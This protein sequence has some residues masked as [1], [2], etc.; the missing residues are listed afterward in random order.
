M[1]I[2]K[3][4][5]WRDILCSRIVYLHSNLHQRD[6]KATSLGV[7]VCKK[8]LQHKIFREGFLKTAQDRDLR[9]KICNIL[10]LEIVQTSFT[11]FQ[12]SHY[13]SIKKLFVKITRQKKTLFSMSFF[14]SYLQQQLKTTFWRSLVHFE[15][16]IS[17]RNNHHRE[18]ESRTAELLFNAFLLMDL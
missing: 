12:S 7:F 3:S 13:S 8:S 18:L 1:N 11:F 10:T 9:L 17:K 2:A 16:N 5:Y 6:I 4:E 14:S 15:T